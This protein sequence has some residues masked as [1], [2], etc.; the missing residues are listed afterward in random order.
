MNTQRTGRRPHERVKAEIGV[1]LLE[2]KGGK[3]CQ[4]PAERGADCPSC[5]RG[6]SPADTLI[7]ASGLQ[8]CGMGDSRCGILATEPHC[9]HWGGLG[10]QADP[11]SSTPHFWR[12]F[13]QV[14]HLPEPGSPHLCGGTTARALLPHQGCYQCHWATCPDVWRGSVPPSA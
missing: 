10:N 5:R 2:A 4:R 3:D 7:S 14:T 8:S 9:L 12:R 13:G 11:G 1:T 6:A